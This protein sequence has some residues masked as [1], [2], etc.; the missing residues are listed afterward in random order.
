MCPSWSSSDEAVVESTTTSTA[1]D[2]KRSSLNNGSTDCTTDTKSSTPTRP[3]EEEPPQ[4]E[5]QPQSMTSE[6]TNKK[7]RRSNS[8]N[9]NSLR[10][11]KIKIYC[12]LDGV[13]VDFN[14]GVM[15]LTGGQHP[16]RMPVG[17]MWAA[18]SRK[19]NFFQQ[20]AWTRDG[21]RLWHAIQ[22]LRPDT[23]DICIL[24]GVPSDRPQIIGQQKA[25]WCRRELG[26]D[27][28]HRD[29]AGQER[30]KN[31]HIRVV[32]TSPDTPPSSSNRTKVNVISCWSKFK[33]KECK[34][35]G[36]I[37]IDDRQKFQHDWEEAGGIFVHHVKTETTLIKLQQ[38]GIM[39]NV[40]PEA[41]DHDDGELQEDNNNNNNNNNHRLET[42]ASNPREKQG[43]QRLSRPRDLMEDEQPETP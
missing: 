2:K 41:D 37:L 36:D 26:I 18:V 6:T 40:D 25:T 28:H 27:V 11:P 7:Q 3:L 35:P 34:N 39:N 13:L 23:F 17:R 29:M 15:Q 21:K 16:D 9:N 12:D 1:M 20:L 5:V 38:L 19:P 30:K 10:V 32:G 31:A 42:K 8:N 24:T 22:K 33:Y 14:R 4:L 43:I